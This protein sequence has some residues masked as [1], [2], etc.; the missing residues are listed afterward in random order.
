VFFYAAVVSFMR[1]SAHHF[2][3][4]KYHLRSNIIYFA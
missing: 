1:R 2:C 3:A 4:E